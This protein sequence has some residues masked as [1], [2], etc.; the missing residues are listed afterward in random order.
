MFYRWPSP[1]DGNSCR[2]AGFIDAMI[3]PNDVQRSFAVRRTRRGQPALS[4][5][6]SPSFRSNSSKSR[7]QYRQ[8]LHREQDQQQG[9]ESMPARL[10]SIVQV[11]VGDPR[12]IPEPI[13]SEISKRRSPMFGRQTAATCERSTSNSGEKKLH[14]SVRD[15]LV[16]A[17]SLIIHYRSTLATRNSRT[18]AKHS[19]ICA[20]H[21][22]G[23]AEWTVSGPFAASNVQY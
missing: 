18:E 21:S 22:A 12:L 7:R 10:G 14:P 16:T 9:A 20:D 8:W 13:F 3:S 6:L 2:P 11:A 23:L 5:R 17:Q 19:E 1:H 4:A 15:Y